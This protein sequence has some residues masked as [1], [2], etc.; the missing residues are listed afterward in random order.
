MENE[1][2]EQLEPWLCGHGSWLLILSDT[3]NDRVAN[4]LFLDNILNYSDFI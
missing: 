2:E 4:N 1:V 3:Q